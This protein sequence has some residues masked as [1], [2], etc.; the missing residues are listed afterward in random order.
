[1]FWSGPQ[2]RCWDPIKIAPKKQRAGVDIS[3]PDV[4]TSYPDLKC[5]IDWPAGRWLGG[6]GGTAAGRARGCKSTTD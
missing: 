1:M 6:D 4:A 5:E 3:T 2:E